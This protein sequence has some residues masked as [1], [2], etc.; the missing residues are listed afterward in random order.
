M[1]EFNDAVS[2]S[3][4]YSIYGLKKSAI[5]FATDII[6]VGENPGFKV[7]DYIKWTSNDGTKTWKAKIIYREFDKPATAKYTVGY[8]LLSVKNTSYASNPG[9]GGQIMLVSTS[10]AVDTGIVKPEPMILGFKT[11]TVIVAFA[12]AVAVWYFRKSIF[13]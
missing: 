13:K 8:Y 7:N 4:G 3:R 1:I 6:G 5:P 2:T 9:D 11:K 10:N 12:L